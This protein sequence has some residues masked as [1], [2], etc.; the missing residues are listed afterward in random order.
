MEYC[1]ALLVQTKA[2]AP[3]GLGGGLAR[4]CCR[5]DRSRRDLPSPSPLLLLPALLVT[6]LLE[7]ALAALGLGGLAVGGGGRELLLLPPR[8]CRRLDGGPAALVNPAAVDEERL[9]GDRVRHRVV[10]DVLVADVGDL[11]VWF[12][13]RGTREETGRGMRGTILLSS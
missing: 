13:E 1:G 3:A 5:S 10:I 8:C 9:P 6:G 7:T 12:R 4:P 2:G 11:S